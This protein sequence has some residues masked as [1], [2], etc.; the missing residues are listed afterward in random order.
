M[1]P[2]KPKLPRRGRLA[3]VAASL[4]VIGALVAAPGVSGAKQAVKQFT[5]SISPTNATGGVAGSWTLTI[6]NCGTPVSPPCTAASTIAIGQVRTTVPT[7]FRPVSITSV[8]ATSPR[9]WTA[10]YDSDTGRI[11]AQA[12][13]GNDKLASGEIASITFSA[14]PTSCATGSKQFTTTALGSLPGSPDGELFSIVGSQPSVNLGGC[15]LESGDSITD[16]VTGQTE[17]ITGNFTGHVL[18]RFGGE[19]GPDCG[20]DVIFGALGDQW[21]QYHLPTQVVITP[22]DDFVPGSGPKVSTSEFDQSILG[23]D[24]SWYLICY[25]SPTAFVT[26]GGGDSVPQTIDGTEFQ[27]GI[28]ASCVDAPTPCVSEQFLTLTTPHQVVISVRIPPNDPYK[29]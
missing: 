24:S 2:L 20:D 9:N 18:V 15:G 28:L 7:E 16:P 11:L 21:Q 25:A 4:L 23:G 10:S 19:E 1:S 29:R 14:T 3:L 17:T 8:T 26:R 6:K 13:T 12:V 5:A 22:G 27:V